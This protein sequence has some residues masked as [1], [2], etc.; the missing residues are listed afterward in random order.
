LMIMSGCQSNESMLTFVF[1]A[2]MRYTAKEENRNS[3]YFPDHLL[4]EIMNNIKQGSNN[5]V[6]QN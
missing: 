4:M 2:D 6:L 1:T 3:S 5:R